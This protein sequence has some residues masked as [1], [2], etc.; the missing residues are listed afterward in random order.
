MGIVELPSLFVSP[1][2][3]D[4]L[5]QCVVYHLAKKRGVV[6]YNQKGRGEVEGSRRK[7]WPQK[8]MGRARVGDRASPVC[9]GTVLSF[10]CS[11]VK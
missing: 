4:I 9:G 3:I 6:Y 11:T 8:R 5:H 7:L 1:V 10:D 2:R